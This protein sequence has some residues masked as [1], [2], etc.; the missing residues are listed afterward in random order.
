MAQPIQE[1]ILYL[2]DQSSRASHWCVW[3]DYY[4]TP[5]Y[6]DVGGVKLEGVGEGGVVC[7]GVCFNRDPASIS[8]NSEH[9]ISASEYHITCMCL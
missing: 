6:T 7:G 2:N 3:C 8:V 5:H 4:I 9:N 1:G